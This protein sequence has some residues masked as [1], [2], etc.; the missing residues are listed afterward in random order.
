MHAIIIRGHNTIGAKTV[1]ITKLS[2]CADVRA[3]PPMKCHKSAKNKFT[4]FF[5]F[6]F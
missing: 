6:N 2:C 5:F 1:S 3:A 4:R